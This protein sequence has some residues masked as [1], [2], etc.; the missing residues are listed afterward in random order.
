MKLHIK[1]RTLTKAKTKEAG[2]SLLSTAL[3][4][5]HWGAPYDLEVGGRTCPLD[6]DAYFVSTS[7]SDYVLTLTPPGKRQS[8]D[9][10]REQYSM[11]R[12][13]KAVVE[14]RRW[15]ET[16]YEFA[17]AFAEARA[18]QA[19]GDGRL[20]Q[21][22]YSPFMDQ[23]NRKF[24]LLD[25]IELLN[26]A[27]GRTTTTRVVEMDP[28]MNKDG[29]AIIDAC[30]AC[31]SALATGDYNA[32]AQ[33]ALDRFFTYGPPS[34]DRRP[35]F[36][37]REEHWRHMVELFKDESEAAPKKRSRDA[38]ESAG[39][40]A[41]LVNDAV[42]ENQLEIGAGGAGD[43]DGDDVTE[44]TPDDAWDRELWMQRLTFGEESVVDVAKR[45][46]AEAVDE[47][48]TEINPVKLWLEMH[49]FET[50]ENVRALANAQLNPNFVR[51]LLES[52]DFGALRRCVTTVRDSRSIRL[53]DC[54]GLGRTV[55]RP[56]T[57][58]RRG[59]RRKIPVDC[60]VKILSD[61]LKAIGFATLWTDATEVTGIADKPTVGTPEYA[62]K[63][64]LVN[65][66][67]TYF[68]DGFTIASANV[69]KTANKHIEG[70]KLGVAVAGSRV[71]RVKLAPYLRLYLGN[72]TRDEGRAL[73]E[74]RNFWRDVKAAEAPVVPE[75][76]AAGDVAQMW[77]GITPPVL[78]FFPFP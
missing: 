75:N 45:I 7:R 18:K 25:D 73:Q 6:F 77:R 33:Y 51:E 30:K 32:K 40:G 76:G 12:R 50:Q 53:Q 55:L 48:D 72:V 49:K 21:F 4:L 14:R 1:S 17:D 20:D 65:V 22:L 38:F 59:P 54:G 56:L 19:S 42:A 78:E 34:D 16:P 15:T 68:D 46:L 11:T 52:K 27:A 69:L 44:D 24:T 5:R 29:H 60:N 57:S 35:R 13:L 2:V 43:D 36:A 31:A 67:N 9:D 62:R 66:C 23:Y 10:A 70:L 71:F 8:L 74:F 63:E 61:L 41:S 37:T 39:R 3:F 28:E 26:Q 64:G 47:D 58:S